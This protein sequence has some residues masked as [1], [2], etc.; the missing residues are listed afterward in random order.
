MMTDEKSNMN[1]NSMKQGKRLI[2]HFATR[3][4]RL[5]LLWVLLLI[6]VVS[7]HAEEVYYA[8]SGFSYSSNK[9]T[10]SSV[11][12]DGEALTSGFEWSASIT[13]G[14]FGT[15]ASPTSSAMTLSSSNSSAQ[16]TLTSHQI[17]EQYI[18]KV[19]VYLG[20]YSSGPISSAVSGLAITAGLSGDAVTDLG[21]LSWGAAPQANSGNAYVLTLDTPQSFEGDFFLKF[22]NTGSG[23]LSITGISDVIIYAQ[24]AEQQSTSYGLTVAGTEV[25][26]ENASRILTPTWGSVSFDIETNTLTLNDASSISISDKN[27]PF[28]KSSLDNLTVYMV[29][30]SSVYYGGTEGGWVAFEADNNPNA[31]ITFKADT[32]NEMLT[33]LSI[34]SKDDDVPV[35]AFSETA[36]FKEITYEGTALYLNETTSRVAIQ[37]LQK[38]SFLYDYDGDQRVYRLGRDSY[39]PADTKYYYSI[40][41]ADDSLEDVT[42]EEY[43]FDDQGNSPTLVIKGP[44]TVTAYC[45]YNDTKSATL[46]GKYFGIEDIT[47][48]FTQAG[49]TLQPTVLPASEGVSFNYVG[50]DDESVATIDETGTIT[51]NGIGSVEFSAYVSSEATDFE[52]LNNP[53]LP[54]T[55]TVTI[56]GYGLK[57]NDIDVHAGNRTNV[58]GDNGE[59]VKFDGHNRLVLNNATALTKIELT[60]SSTWSVEE[61]LEVYLQGDNA[62]ANE[63]GV[64]FVCNAATASYNLTFTT[65]ASKPGTLTYTTTGN[66]LNA[67]NAIFSG[68]TPKYRN[69]LSATLSDDQKMVTIETPLTPIIEDDGTATGDEVIE[70]AIVYGNASS[71]HMDSE[72]VL[73]TVIIDNVLYTLADDGTAA[74]DGF[75]NSSGKVVLHSTMTDADV[76]DLTET[77]GT[78]TEYASAFKGLTFMVPAGTG[79]ITLDAET[80]SG[81]EFHL[82]VGSQDPVTVINTKDND[83]QAYA[84]PY[85]TANAAYVYLYLVNTAAASAAYDGP[86]KIGPKSGV[87]GG[88]GSLG[89]SSSASAIASAVS[90][91]AASYLM[92]TASMVQRV[93]TGGGITVTDNNI[94]DI[95]A[96]AFGGGSGAPRRAAAVDKSSTTFI[97]LSQTAIVGK[98]VSRSSGAFA[99][100]PEETIIY[101]P[102]GNTSTEPNVVIGGICEHLKLNGAD[103]NTMTFEMTSNVSSFTAAK[104]T[105]E[106]TFA[107]DKTSTVCLPFAISKPKDYGTFATVTKIDTEKMEVTLSS[108][109]A[110]VSANTPYVFTPSVTKLAVKNATVVKGDIATG[111]LHGTYTRKDYDAGMYCYAGQDEAESSIEQ[112]QFVRMGAR[113]WVPPFRAYMT[114][115]SG[116]PS[117]SVVWDDDVVTAVE[118]VETLAEDDSAAWYDLSGRRLSGKPAQKGL[119]IHNG[120]KYVNK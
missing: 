3:L 18:T 78:T 59:T 44:A 30:S 6:S 67:A 29:G 71:S 7:A 79:T 86:N 102:A 103:D 16:I 37:H 93:G 8:I 53:D 17:T 19:V 68:F 87:G 84:I 65:E 61:G 106:R 101:M 31:T 99:G 43:V 13:G 21:S 22:S 83:N 117:F 110:T 58:L 98:E 66:V 28:I 27:T 108:P 1:R 81:Y 38:P 47:V 23:S 74:S 64:A 95:D 70:T 35:M 73:N 94:T 26:S 9:L 49:V 40:D 75:D 77:P 76:A 107:S 50:A 20:D 15:Q 109:A 5:S 100:F 32:E 25:T 85:V 4:N 105:L 96:S 111:N 41:Y 80:T 113:S 116:A 63:D 115:D 72:T 90:S 97:D 45:Q 114:S 119:Y 57:V 24:D 88:L 54:I 2:N 10:A 120:K 48:D 36:P 39:G 11:T 104:A 69:Q 91:P 55:F 56:S 14:Y 62:V 112:G 12:K 82:K 92:C 34:N 118:A 89:V 60:P 52:L 42:D 46:V 51:V 33:P